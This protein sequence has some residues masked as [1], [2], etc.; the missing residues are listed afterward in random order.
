M[1]KA[2]DKGSRLE[3]KVAKLIRQK[4]LD[5]KAR[6]MPL[7]GAW[8]HFPEDIYTELPVHIECK[9][10]EKL[11]IW[12]WWQKIRH[13]H[14]PILVVSGN[15]RPILAVVDIDYLL[16]LL[17]TEQDYLNDVSRETVSTGTEG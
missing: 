11:R 2:K 5:P 14:N 12:E 10:Q 9:N 4:G 3:R 15:Y 8:S 1:S 13:R 6:R 16:D 17:K 7:S